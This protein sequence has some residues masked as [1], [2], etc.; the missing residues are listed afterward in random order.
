M[1]ATEWAGVVDDDADEE[2]AAAAAAAGE[3][4]FEAGSF[5]LGLIRS[6]YE[7]VRALNVDGGAE[8]GTVMSVLK[9]R[10]SGK[11][12]LWSKTDIGKGKQTEQGSQRKVQSRADAGLKNG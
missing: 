12:E 8:E 10:R 3:V 2:D 1:A 11:S 4:E 5:S 9:P 6:A 7:T